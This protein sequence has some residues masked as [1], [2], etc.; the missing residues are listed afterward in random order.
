M[1]LSNND[2]KYIAKLARLNVTETEVEEFSEQLSSILDYVAKLQEVNTDNVPELQHA[3]DVENVF[4]DDIIEQS[5]ES[6]RISAIENFS[7]SNGNLLEV[8]SVFGRNENL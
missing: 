2:V 7:N 5:D 3:L 1:P 6:T 4:R 8:Q